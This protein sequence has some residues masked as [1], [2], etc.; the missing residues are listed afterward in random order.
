[1]IRTRT[2]PPGD[3]TAELIIAEGPER[4]RIIAVS[5]NYTT[6]VGPATDRLP[7]LVLQ[8][9]NLFDFAWLQSNPIADGKSFRM[10]WVGSSARQV[11]S[12]DGTGT[13]LLGFFPLPDIWLEPNDRVILST[14]NADAADERSEVVIRYE[15]R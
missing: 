9:G 1:V 7:V 6:A 15:Q 12:Y 3:P 2:F 11:D 10:S 5:F 13:I 14:F 4:N 8:N